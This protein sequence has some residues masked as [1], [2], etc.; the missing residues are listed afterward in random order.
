MLLPVIV[1]RYSLEVRALHNNHVTVWTT[2]TAST[3]SAQSV[4]Q[5]C[6]LA[7][8]VFLYSLVLTHE[9]MHMQ[10]Q[11]HACTQDT[12]IKVH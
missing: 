1:W 10:K 9:C 12:I 8:S 5:A 6:Q 2:V 7:S 11:T 3:C 4:G